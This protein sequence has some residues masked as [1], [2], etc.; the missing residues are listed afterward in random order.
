MLLVDAIVFDL[1]GTLWDT[2]AACAVGWN[3]VLRRRS[4]A[5][6]EVTE[7]DV[8]AVVG[9][10]HDACIREV[11]RGL[12]EDELRILVDDTQEEDNRIVAELG[13]TLYPGVKSGLERLS[14]TRP[15]HIVSNCQSGYIETFLQFTGLGSLFRD[16][17][18]WGNTKLPKA[19]NLRSVIARNSLLAPVFVGDTEGDRLAAAACGVPFVHASYGFGDCAAADF[20]LSLFSELPDLLGEP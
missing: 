14:R 18:C 11:F 1:D 6:R 19:E 3:R 10:T 9:R 8:R 7:R 17:E 16:F 12:P 15:L 5:F 4:I 20:R 13:G 2:C